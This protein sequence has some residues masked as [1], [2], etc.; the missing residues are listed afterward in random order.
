MCQSVVSLPNVI[1][2]VRKT[3]TYSKFVDGIGYVLEYPVV[4]IDNGTK[5][6]TRLSNGTDSSCYVYQAVFTKGTPESVKEAALPF[7]SSLAPIPKETQKSAANLTNV[8]AS[9]RLRQLDSLLK[10]KLI[11]EDEFNKRRSIILDT[12]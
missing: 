4:E 11:S 10:E 7:F 2:E 1:A 12:L 5:M 6:L 9:E 8:P 3:G